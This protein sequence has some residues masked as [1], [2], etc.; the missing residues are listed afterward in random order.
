MTNRVNN[1]PLPQRGQHPL[2]ATSSGDGKA[3]TDVT[4][5]VATGSLSSKGVMNN[6][7]TE[8]GSPHVNRD[9]KEQPNHVDEMPIP[10]SGLETEMLARCEVTFVNAHQTNC[11]KYRSDHDVK[12]METSRH[13]EGRAINVSGETKLGVVIFEGLNTTED[14]PKD[15]CDPEPLLER[16]AVAVDKRVMRP[17][18]C[19]TRKKQYQCI[20]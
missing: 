2:N 6:R 15:D 19:R 5:P 7:G 20:E 16:L 10:G 8:F 3:A 4:G 12:T 14:H 11:Q 1:L 13:V 9:E 17:C 18:D